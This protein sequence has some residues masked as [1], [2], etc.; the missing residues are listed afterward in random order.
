M[1]KMIK[2]LLAFLLLVLVSIS[3]LFYQINSAFNQSIMVVGAK[4]L[5]VKQG[6]YAHYII[7]RLSEQSLLLDPL[8][9]KAAIKIE[10]HYAEVKAGTYELK[11]GMTVRDLFSDLSTGNEKTFQISLIEGLTWSQWLSQ[12][13]AHP[14]IQASD[15]TSE[16]WVEFL[17]PDLPGGSTEGWLLPDTY[18]FTASTKAEDIVKRAYTAMKL[19]LSETWANRALELPYASSYEALIMA[20]IIEKET[21]AA[22]ER[23][24]ISGVFVNRLNDNMRL[25]TDPTVI[26]GM[27][28]SFDGNIR[29]QDLRRPTAYNTYVIKGLPPTPIA[30]PGK[31]SIEAALNPLATSDYYFV[32]KG[33][34]T[35][36]FSATLKEHNM[37]VKKYQLK[38]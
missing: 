28:D 14:K 11:L 16:Q 18:Q 10:P 29:R 26:Y 31:L 23:P 2:V 38:K 3:A 15:K 5:V 27:G 8:L 4:E 13:N 37:A 6:Q 35:H 25:Q 20:S 17:Q 34:G 19:F 7:N 12:I 21:G 1:S 36:K 32:S 9:V 24:R 33:D 22:H 30:M